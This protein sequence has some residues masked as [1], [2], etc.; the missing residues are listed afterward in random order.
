MA[1][2]YRV[3]VMEHRNGPLWAVITFIIVAGLNRLIGMVFI[4]AAVGLVASFA[5][6]FIVK[7]IEEKNTEK[8]PP[9]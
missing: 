2:M 7:L 8:P 9:V 6:M 4:A 5:A 3:A 1:V